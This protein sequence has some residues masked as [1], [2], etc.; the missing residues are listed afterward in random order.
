MTLERE[1]CPDVV[2]IDRCKEYRP[3][4]GY[5]PFIDRCKEYRPTAGYGPFHTHFRL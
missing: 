1:R 2:F 3:T 4:A 5:G